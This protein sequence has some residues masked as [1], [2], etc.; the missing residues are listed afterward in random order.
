[1]W[2]RDDVKQNDTV[3]LHGSVKH[4]QSSS[5]IPQLSGAQ[6]LPSARTVLLG[7]IISSQSI[8]VLYMN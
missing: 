8:Q 1:M 7:P 6:A 5:S 2:G 4:I 3:Y